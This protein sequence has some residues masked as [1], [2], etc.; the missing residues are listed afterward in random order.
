MEGKLVSLLQKRALVETELEGL[1]EELVMLPGFSFLGMYTML[2][3][4]SRGGVLTSQDVVRFAERSTS[5]LE[6]KVASS[7]IYRRDCVLN[8]L[9][10]VPLCLRLFKQKHP[11]RIAYVEVGRYGSRRGHSR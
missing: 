4:A 6:A 11:E 1:K 8:T 9:Q 7:C 3:R 10:Q 5:P 2:S